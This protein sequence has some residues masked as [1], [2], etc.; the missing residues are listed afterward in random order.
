[1]LTTGGTLVTDA[2]SKDI[3]NRILTK[4]YVDLHG[5]MRNNPSSIATYLYSH[6]FISD[7]TLRDVTTTVGESNDVKGHKLLQ[8]CKQNILTHQHPGERLRELLDILRDVEPAVKTVADR[9][10]EK[11]SLFI[12]QYTKSSVVVVAVLLR[13]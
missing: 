9:I 2:P 4:H 10:I 6:L 5:A 7:G 3:I 1:M 13:E 11:V 8:E 12:L